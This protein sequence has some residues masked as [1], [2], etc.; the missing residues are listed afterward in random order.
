MSELSFRVRGN[1]FPVILLHGF[2][3]NQNIWDSFADKLA[4]HYK[5][6]TVDLPG[7][8]GSPMPLDQLSIDQVAKKILDWIDHEGLLRSVI[9]GHSLGGYIVLAMAEQSPEKFQGI[10]L[11]HSTALADTEEK[12]Q[13]RSKVIDFVQ[14]NGALAFTSNFIAPLFANP[15]HPAI[16]CVRELSSE[17]TDEAVVKYT[18]A[19]RDRSDRTAFLKAFLNPILFIAG[20]KDAGIPVESIAYQASLCLQPSLQILK[21]VAHMGMVEDEAR[22]LAI[23]EDFVEKCLQ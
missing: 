19:M 13:S 11:F 9:I 2:P 12:R 8:G 16:A 1:G 20:E 23:V 18:L 22:T 5:V 6:Y 15:H 14:T 7:F 4:L 3:M 10:G 17:A 21:D